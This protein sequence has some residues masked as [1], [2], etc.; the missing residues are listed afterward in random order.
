MAVKKWCPH[1][2]EVMDLNDCFFCFFKHKE[3]LRNERNS[4]IETNP[5]QKGSTNKNDLTN[6]NSLEKN[7]NQKSLNIKTEIKI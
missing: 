5:M 4:T 7:I 6:P 2:K 1:F 3:E